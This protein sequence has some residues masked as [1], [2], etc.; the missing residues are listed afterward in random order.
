MPDDVA[1]YPPLAEQ[2]VSAAQ[3]RHA[4]RFGMWIFLATEVLFFGGLFLAYFVYRHWYYQEF[5]AGSRHLDIVLGTLN[6]AVLLTSS[7]FMAGALTAAEKFDRRATLTLLSLTALLGLAFLGIKG[8]EWHDAAREGFWPGE[9]WITSGQ[10]SHGVRLFY[11][12][13]Y[14]MTGLHGVHLIIG[15]TAI[16]VFI[17]RLARLRPFAPNQNQLIILGLY[18]HFIDIVWI[19]LYPLLYFIGRSSS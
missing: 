9:K 7:F 5:V 10:P 3:Q 13:Y 18:W 1:P 19:F 4:A 17:W 6:T 2:F 11:S 14:V 12:L 16:S 8:Y 15:I